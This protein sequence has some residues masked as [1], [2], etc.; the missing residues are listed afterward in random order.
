MPLEHSHQY[1][2]CHRKK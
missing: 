2:W 1:Y